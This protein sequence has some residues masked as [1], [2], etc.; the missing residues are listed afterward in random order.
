MSVSD[1]TRNNEWFGKNYLGQIVCK[2]CGTVHRDEENFLVHLEAKRHHTNIAAKERARKLQEQQHNI[3]MRMREDRQKQ[4]LLERIG[5]ADDP[6]AAIAGKRAAAATAGIPKVDHHLERENGMCHVYFRVHY[7]LAL[8]EGSETGVVSRPL[9]RWLGT[10]ETQVV[11]KDPTVQYLVFAC[12][13]YETV[14]FVFPAQRNVTTANNTRLPDDTQDRY[15][16]KWD[17]VEKVYT[18]IFTIQ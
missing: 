9:H 6:M 5:A 2:L 7:P 14:A 18:L 17:P 8:T 15:S 3:L 1:K 10:Y 12:E 16:C 11:P 13:P 4:D